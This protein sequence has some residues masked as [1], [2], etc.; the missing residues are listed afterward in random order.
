MIGDF[1][2]SFNTLRLYDN[3]DYRLSHEIQFVQSHHFSRCI[4]MFL[5]VLTNSSNISIHVSKL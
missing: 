1:F 2:S 4:H 5:E 3:I